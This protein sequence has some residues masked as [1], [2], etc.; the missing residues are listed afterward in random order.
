MHRVRAVHRVVI[1]NLSTGEQAQLINAGRSVVEI[2]TSHFAICPLC[3]REATILASARKT[4]VRIGCVHVVGLERSAG[5]LI[6]VFFDEVPRQ[7]R[8]GVGV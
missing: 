2:E 4:H 8:A 5:H 7:K 6:D 3:S 1:A